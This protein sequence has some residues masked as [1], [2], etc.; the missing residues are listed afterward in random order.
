[1]VT[2]YLGDSV[3]VEMEGGMLKLTTNNGLGP[4]NTIYLDRDV[5]RALEAYVARLRAEGGFH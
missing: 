4:T 2:E 5:Y 3:Y 1:V